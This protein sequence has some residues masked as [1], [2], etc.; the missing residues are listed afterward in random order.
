MIF[1]IFFLVT[2]VASS[3]LSNF[4][5]RK[6]LQ[7][8]KDALNKCEDIK[9][10]LGSF[11]RETRQ[12]FMN[13]SINLNQEEVR[14]YIAIKE[15]MICL[16]YNNDSIDFDSE[17][18]SI[19]NLFLFNELPKFESFFSQANLHIVLLFLLKASSIVILH[20]AKEIASGLAHK[21]TSNQMNEFL[22]FRLLDSTKSKSTSSTDI[23]ERIRKLS[24]T[25]DPEEIYSIIVESSK[26]NIDIKIIYYEK[27]AEYL[28]RLDFEAHPDWLV[29]ILD[30]L[31]TLF[32]KNIKSQKFIKFVCD[33]ILSD[34]IINIMKNSS[35]FNESYTFLLYFAFSE[36]ESFSTKFEPVLTIFELSSSPY[37]ETMNIIFKLFQSIKF[38][39]TLN[40][41]SNENDFKVAIDS[42]GKL[43]K[44]KKENYYA[45]QVLKAD[46]KY[47]NSLIMN[48][49]AISTSEKHPL[50]T[51]SLMVVGMIGYLG[52]D[53]LDDEKFAVGCYCNIVS[54]F[55]HYM[56]KHGVESELVSNFLEDFRPLMG[57]AMEGL[58]NRIKRNNT[59]IGKNNLQSMIIF[60]QL[61]PD[62]VERQGYIDRIYSHY[63]SDVQPQY[64]KY[65][66]IVD[67]EINDKQ[68]AYVS[69]F[70]TFLKNY[71]LHPSESQ[72]P[73]LKE[74]YTFLKDSKLLNKT[75]LMILEKCFN[76]FKYKRRIIKK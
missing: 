13:D 21:L 14:E 66:T 67:R 72:L 62:S 69:S 46:Y 27:L 24:T 6:D 32:L 51:L 55:G 56:L 42:F 36:P 76:G 73:Y 3:K 19:F 34:K 30:A 7:D 23:E 39:V 33:F 4:S 41:N 22:K 16:L 54:G 57:I 20:Q 45:R 15:E 1:S 43:I 8:L 11:T 10:I 68:G 64:S 12:V 26:T 17:E 49:T 48:F 75:E 47:F 37:A 70:L 74:Y 61:I 44:L 31:K 9:P 60:S 35:E 59:F 50:F 65:Y 29:P 71:A 53:L 18:I 28:H 40:N 58:L 63:I 2:F 38:V 5:F 25:S 52:H